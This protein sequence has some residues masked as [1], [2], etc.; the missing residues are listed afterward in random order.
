[1]GTMTASEPSPRLR[2]LTGAVLDIERHASS[3]GWESPVMVF[4]LVRTAAALA[5]NP[6]LAAE[7]PDGAEESARVDPEHLLSVEQDGLPQADSLEEL[8]AQLAWPQEVDGAALVVERMVVPPEAET[9]MPSD[10]DQA[11]AY[12][13]AHPDRKDV[14]ITVGVL[15]TGESWCALRSRSNDTDDDVAGSPD[16]VPGLVAALQATFS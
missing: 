7:L 8:L 16:A 9:G 13:E 5:A 4:S 2:A 6:S 10:P 12:L 1:M 11:V 3:L 14:R 15:R